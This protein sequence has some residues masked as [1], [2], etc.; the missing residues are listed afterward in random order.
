[1]MFSNCKKAYILQFWCLLM[2]G[3]ASFQ[4]GQSFTIYPLIYVINELVSGK[5][6]TIARS[7]LSIG[8]LSSGLTVVAKLQNCNKRR[9]AD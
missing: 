8:L 5:K 7:L 3:F 6:F 2:P 9:N 1:M 4:N